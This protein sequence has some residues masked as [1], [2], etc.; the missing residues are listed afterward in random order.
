[1]K[2]CCTYTFIKKIISYAILYMYI[3]ILLTAEMHTSFSSIV[4]LCRYL[5]ENK[6]N[7]I[8]LTIT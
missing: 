3:H 2:L 8:L 4:T 6:K 1:M 7:N 5:P